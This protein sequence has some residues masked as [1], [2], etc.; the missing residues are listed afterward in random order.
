MQTQTTPCPLCDQSDGPVIWQENGFRGR[1]HGCGVVLMDPFPNADQLD[2]THEY[3]AEGYYRFPVRHRLQW[4]R[5]FKQKGRLLEVGAGTGWFLIAA[6][7]AGFTATGLE[8]HPQRAAAARARGLEIQQST[9][10]EA[11]LEPKYDLIFHVDLLSHFPDPEQALR[12][13]K[14]GLTPNGLLVFEVGVLGGMSSWWYRLVGGVGYPQHMRLYS[15]KAL[16]ALFERVGLEP[17]AVRSHGLLPSILLVRLRRLL[18]PLLKRM[19]PVGDPNQQAAGEQG[20]LHQFYD[21]LQS[22]LRYRVGRLT[23][24]LGPLTLFV[25]LKPVAWSRDD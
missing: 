20:R 8:P 6:H 5:R 17:V 11:H 21:R 14:Q 10:E 4:L 3:H 16:K 15:R 24:P 7:E 23:P 19:V 25:A 2:E 9:I 12:A 1:A 13:M 18:W 22:F